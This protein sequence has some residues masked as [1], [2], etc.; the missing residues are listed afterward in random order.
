MLQIKIAA[1]F[2]TEKELDRQMARMLDMI[3]KRGP[4][5]YERFMEV[6]TPDY[7]W[8]VENFRDREEDM[9]SKGIRFK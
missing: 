6:L 7:P 3:P 8:I 4:E 5:A 1:I 2:Q 9:K